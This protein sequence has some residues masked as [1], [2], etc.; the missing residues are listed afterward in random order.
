MREDLA[1][2]IAI[3][4]AG[5]TLLLALMF[6]YS[7]NIAPPVQ[8]TKE[9]PALP[10]PPLDAK[11]RELVQPGRSIYKEQHCSVCHSVEGSGNPR[12]PLDGVGDRLGPEDIRKWIIG[13]EE[14]K[15]QMP[16]RAFRIKQDYKEL[17]PEE[18]YALVA[19]MQSLRNER[20]AAFS[21]STLPLFSHIEP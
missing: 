8:T 11:R 6:S 21:C 7:Q 2:L 18:L 4:T 17:P 1:K 13:A 14:L 3:L 20:L 16:G 15:L 9:T 5:L 12:Y 19:Y 10:P